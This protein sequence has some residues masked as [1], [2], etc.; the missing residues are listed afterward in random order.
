MSYKRIDRNE[1]E[2]MD[3]VYRLNLMNSISGYKSANLIGTEENGFSNLA[4]FSS[5]THLGS[6][7]PLLGMINRPNTV[8]RHSL[9]NLRKTGVYTINHIF[10]GITENAHYTS[11]K[12]DKAESEFDHCVIEKEYI[13]DFPAPFVKESPVKLGMRLV[14]EIPIKS[15]GTILIVGEIEIAEIAERLITESGQLDLN[16]GKVVAI[17]GLNRYHQVAQIAH[18][19]YARKEELPSFQR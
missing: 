10:E 13:G 12:F 16:Q 1:I 4:I 15:N 6:N 14:E 9:D 5:V 2:E 3:R 18:Y 17:S 7:P 8:E 11:A 19:P